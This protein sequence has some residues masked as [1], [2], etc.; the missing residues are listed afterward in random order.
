MIVRRER[1]E[2]AV[3]IR[4]VHTSAFTSG[5]AVEAPLVDRLRDDGDLIAAVSLVAIDRDDAIIAHVA[6]S[7][8]TVAGRPTLGLGPLGVRRAF[9]RR[10][11]GQA[12]MHAVIGAADA[13]DEPA[14][15]L[16]GDPVFYGRF[17]FVP[18]ASVR[19]IAPDP[20]WSEHFQAR[21]LGAWEPA[22]R[23]TFAYAPAFGL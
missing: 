13:L 19:V 9:Q 14:V 20:G 6:C 7:R 17:G 12:L 8:A 16:L 21:R 23:G 2:D 5:A 22:L 1:P 18:A 4:A 11:A 10:G 3:A 15:F